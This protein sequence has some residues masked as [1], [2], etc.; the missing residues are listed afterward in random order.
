MTTFHSIGSYLQEQIQYYIEFYEGLG[1]NWPIATKTNGKRYERATFSN[2]EFFA[3]MNMSPS[4]M[5]G[6]KCWPTLSTHP[7]GYLRGLVTLASVAERLHLH[8]GLTGVKPRPLAGEAVFR[9]L[10]FSVKQ[11]DFISVFI[12]TTLLC[13]KAFSSHI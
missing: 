1:H 2:R 10:N 12:D 13:Y 11:Y 4:L 7:Y 6:F 3:L 9:A 5:T 8:V